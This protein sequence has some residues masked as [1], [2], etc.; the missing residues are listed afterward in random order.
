MPFDCL[1][2]FRFLDD[3]NRRMP[4]PLVMNRFR[5]NI[6][7]T[8]CSEP[9]DEDRIARMRIGGIEFRGTTLC[10]RCRISVTNQLTAE[11]GQEPL[12]TLATY[13]KSW[14]MVSSSAGTLIILAGNNLGG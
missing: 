11:Y 3:L 8:G 6:V 2:T 13:R 7:I 4:A 1:T 10:V 12:R 9:Y 14:R 5:P